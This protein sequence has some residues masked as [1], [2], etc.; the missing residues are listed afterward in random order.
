MPKLTERLAREA[1][2]N[3]TH[4][5]SEIGGFALVC[6]KQA[7]TWFFQKDI[8]GKT[9]R[10]KI[11]RYPAV[12]AANARKV[13]LRLA[14]DH[15]TGVGVEKTRDD[16][17]VPTLREATDAY[18]A[19]PK[20]R[21]E[22]NKVSVRS[23]MKHLHDWMDKPLDAISRRMCA[24]RHAALLG[25]KMG[26]TGANHVMQS[27]RSIW[28]HARRTCDLPECPTRSIEWY[29]ERPPQ[30]IIEDFDQ[31]HALVEAI[32]NPIHK[33]FYRMLLL[34]GLRRTECASLRWEHVHEDH[35]HIPVTKN[36]RP[37]DL[38]IL[39][40]HHAILAAMRGLSSEWV[41]P[42]WRGDTG[43]M[44]E[45]TRLEKAPGEFITCHMHRRTFA[46]MADRAGVFPEV[47]GRLLNHTPTTVTQRHYV[48]VD[49]SR[50]RAP[51]AEVVGAFKRA[52][53][54]IFAES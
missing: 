3:S 53:P 50:L 9:R 1:P 18:L 7:R 13:A 16:E 37:F 20:L 28:N 17:K 11:G 26:P 4:W 47:V 39:P 19:R 54:K 40:E 12:N 29:E 44:R 51:M 30:T 15:S 32:G 35:L 31:W 36:G 2:T 34:T 43:H 25:P 21:S 8:R 27:F 45:P 6:G 41:F 42:A 52:E 33:A 38:P 49:H 10:T 46:T 23:H 24:D 14:L 5:D 22:N 48:A